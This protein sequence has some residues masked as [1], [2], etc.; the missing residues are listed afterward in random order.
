MKKRA[1]IILMTFILGF[2]GT[3]SPVCSASARGS[4][5]E[6]A[7][8]EE[9][10]ENTAA[11]SEQKAA[12][13]TA[14]QAVENAVESAAAE[15]VENAAAEAVENAVEN[16]GANSAQEAQGSIPQQAAQFGSSLYNKM[17]EAVDSMDKTSLR[18][19][20]RDALGELDARGISPSVVVERTLGIRTT[21]TEKG[22]MPE[23]TLIEGAEKAVRKKTEGFFTM[24]WKGFLGALGG[25]ITTGMSVLSED[26][27]QTQSVQG[28]SK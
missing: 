17:D 2:A 23:N 11:D 6:S 10:A 4:T 22:K 16:A 14:A 19:N 24:L 5:A 1:L 21:V 3:L 26:T 25:M 8:E 20:I 13:S 9:P 12:E 27:A 7:L 28:G 18:K 15:A